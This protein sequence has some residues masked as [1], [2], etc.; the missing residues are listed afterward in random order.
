MHVKIKSKTYCAEI[1]K[2]QKKLQFFSRFFPLITNPCLVRYVKKTQ[3]EA[4][5][6]ALETLAVHPSFRDMSGK[7]KKRVLDD[8]MLSLA[9]YGTDVDGYALHYG[10]KEKRKEP[11]E[12]LSH[13]EFAAMIDTGF[14]EETFQLFQDK[15][16]LF[17]KLGPF[18][19]REG[20]Y[21]KRKDQLQECIRFLTG[22]RDLML[23][24]VREY[25]GY[26]IRHILVEAGNEEKTAEE[27]LNQ[28]P[29]LLEERVNQSD[30]MA[31]LNPSSVNT[32]RVVTFR[33]EQESELIMTALRVGREGSI[34][35]NYSSG[36][37]FV[38]VDPDTHKTVPFSTGNSITSDS[39]IH[40]DSGKDLSG[41]E[42][43][44]WEGAME[45]VRKAAGVFPPDAHIFGWDLAHT[46][47]GW[48]VIEVNSTPG[49]IQ[50]F[51]GPQATKM[52]ARFAP[53]L[54]R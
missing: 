20:L 43:P 28:L 35:D 29:C 42:V 8:M 45:L 48:L 16:E 7:E 54:K 18:C 36:G 14:T 46:D 31:W 9:L 33:G 1:L 22:H 50:D 24:P 51:A 37:L 25:G 19:G 39:A 32:M 47:R 5:T 41:F 30:R 10:R 4:Y 13:L 40:P 52:R 15:G 26:G 11:K 3:K 12:Y 53:Y 49:D 2:L 34:V 27:L 23:K 38:K 6:E 21:L 17:E 44:D